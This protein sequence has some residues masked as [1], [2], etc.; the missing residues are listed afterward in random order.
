MTVGATDFVISDDSLGKTVRSLTENRGVDHAFECVGRSSTITAAWRSTRRGGAL[1]VVGM[2]KRD[3]MISLGALE[4]FNSAR[5][6][7]SSFFGS[8]D[9]DREVPELAAA[10]LD[11]SLD[12]TPLI[13]HRIALAQA[14]EAFDRMEKGVGARSV[15]LFE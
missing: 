1:T 8:S 3:D 13:S 11:G 4:V 7:R 12:L 5:T 15:V 9:P 6:L 10:V 2:G 14:T